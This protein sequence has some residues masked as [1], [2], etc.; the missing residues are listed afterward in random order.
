MPGCTAEYPHDWKEGTVKLNVTDGGV[1]ETPAGKFENTVHLTISCEVPGNPDDYG[2][3][4]YDNTDCGVKEYWFAPG[5][6]VVRF[7]CAWG[8]HLTSDCLLTDYH[9]VAAPGEMMP[10]HIGNRWRYEEQYL[11]AENYIARR[12]YKI[13][14]GMGDNYTLADSQFFTWRGNV[15]EYEEFKRNLAK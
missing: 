2:Y 13:L 8:R 6:G 3:Y 1:I 14:S 15:E 11:T 9:T 5:V 7:K 10:I 12:D 4:F